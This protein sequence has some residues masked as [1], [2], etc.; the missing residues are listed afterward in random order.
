A[1]DVYHV[2]FDPGLDVQVARAGMAGRILAFHVSD[3]RVPTRDLLLDRAM[4]GDGAIDIPRIR[5]RVEDA[6]YDG[7]IEVEIFS[8]HD[9]WRRDAEEVLTIVAE[10]FRT[11]V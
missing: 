9:W 2:W 5:G 1:I 10:R 7:L 11:A 4:M 6:G 3:W 8:Q